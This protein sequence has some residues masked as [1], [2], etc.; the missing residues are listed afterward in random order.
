LSHEQ[1]KAACLDRWNRLR[2]EAQRKYRQLATI[3]NANER[4]KAERR[5][6]KMENG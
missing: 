5:I 2:D 4:Q 3:S 6:R 1:H